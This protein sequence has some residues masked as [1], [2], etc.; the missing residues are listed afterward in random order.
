[1]DGPELVKI[2]KIN[3]ISTQPSHSARKKKI[4]ERIFNHPFPKKAGNEKKF[5]EPSE[6]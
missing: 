4:R 3:Q 2:S 1:L 6:E 5:P